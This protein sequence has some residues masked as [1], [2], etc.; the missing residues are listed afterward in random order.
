MPLDVNTVLIYS[1]HLLH[2][3][4]QNLCFWLIKE[5]IDP[6]SINDNKIST[7]LIIFKSWPLDD[8]GDAEDEE[9]ERHEDDDQSDKEWEQGHCE[10][11]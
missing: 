6:C 10:P 7:D 4:I 3:P 1:G 11:G 9:A 8:L 2:Q 5:H